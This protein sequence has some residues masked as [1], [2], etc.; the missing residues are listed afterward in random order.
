MS[1]DVKSD[2]T[3]CSCADRCSGS[4]TPAASSRMM[5]SVRGRL[6]EDEHSSSSSPCRVTCCKLNTHTHTS[7]VSVPVSVGPQVDSEFVS[8]IRFFLEERFV[9]CSA[10]P[11]HLH[12]FHILLCLFFLNHRWKTL[13]FSQRESSGVCRAQFSYKAS[14]LQGWADGGEA[15]IV[16]CFSLCSFFDWIRFTHWWNITA[17]SCRLW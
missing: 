6:E 17:L 8:W 3:T 10:Q 9:L 13:R 5:L 16:L 11:E 4:W 14:L 2:V 12:K 15:V 1:S 7:Q